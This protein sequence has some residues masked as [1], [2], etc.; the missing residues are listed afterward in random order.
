MQDR[1][2][3]RLLLE[4]GQNVVLLC[5]EKAEEDCHRKVLPYLLLNEEEL[6]TY[7]GELVFEEDGEQTKLTEQTKLDWY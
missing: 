2:D 5:H 4:R 6:D 3:I 7:K 1:F